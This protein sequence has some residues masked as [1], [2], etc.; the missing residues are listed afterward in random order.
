MQNKGIRILLWVLTIAMCVVIFAFSEQDGSKSMETS[1]VI[2]EPIAKQIASKGPP[3]TK[4][5]YRKL[6]DE[7]QHY[8]RKTAHFSEYALLSALVFLLMTSYGKHRRGLISTLFCALY[9]SGDELHQLIGGSRTGMWQDV[10]LD[11][12]GAAVGALVC[13]GILGLT[14]SM[15][16]KRRLREETAK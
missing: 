3:M 15:L 12:C 9:A 7:V 1:G 13:W 14:A 11:T 8:V 6:L 4:S 10:L 16:R 5:Q 2:A